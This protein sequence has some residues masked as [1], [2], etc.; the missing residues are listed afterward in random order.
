MD[1]LDPVLLGRIQF[2]LTAVYHFIF[3]PLSIGIGLIM[4]IFETKAFRSGSEKDAAAARF[5]VKLFTVTFAVG[6]ATGITMEFSFGTNWADYS[7][8]VGDI[9]GAPLAAEALFAFFLESVFL[10]VLLFGRNKVSSLFYTVSA[11]LVWAGSCLSALWILIANSWMQTPAGAELNADGT[12]AVISGDGRSSVTPENTTRTSLTSV[13]GRAAYDYDNRYYAE[14]SFRYDGSS[15]FRSDLRWGFFPSVSLGWRLSQEAFMESYRDNVGDLKIR[16]SYGTLGNQSVGDYQYFT[17]YNVYSNTY[18]FNN[19]GVGGAGFQ[20]GTDNLQ[21]EVSKTFNVGFDASFFR[22]KL[23]L[24]FDYFNKHTTDILV[25]PQTPLIL[26]TELQNYNAGEM[27][28]QGWELTLSYALKKRDWSH[29]FQFNIGD[30]W[31]KVLKYEGF[32]DISGQEEFWRIT[33]EGLP[34]NSYYGYKTDGFFQSYDEIAHSAVPTGKSVKPGDVK[35]KDRNGD[36]TIDENDRY[37]LGN[38]FPRYTVG[39]TYNVAWKGIDLSIFLQGVLKRDMMVRGELIEPFHS[40][41]GYTM[42]EHQLDFWTP[43]NTDAR[44]PRLTDI[45]DPSNQNNYRMGSDLYMFDGSYLRLKNIQLGYTL[46]ERISMKFGV[47]R[48]KI[49]FNAQNLLTFSNCSFIDPESSEFGS[50]MNSGGANSGRNYPNLRY[51]GAGLNIT[52]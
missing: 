28:T 9:F 49:Y 3:V 10:G 20:L 31:N 12:E 37:Y 52:F 21:W 14:F 51:F 34:F 45:S 33:R 5:W 7:R 24:G 17:T 35:F 1:W 22:G 4:A 46:P 15:K 16:G 41:Y 19:V 38:A 26:G 40:N 48:F 42:Y 2:T 6:V 23:N 8:F 30:S 32:E 39:F 13:F 29:F 36:G 43:T 25:K 50:N 11:W 27:R 47:K 18:A 44:W